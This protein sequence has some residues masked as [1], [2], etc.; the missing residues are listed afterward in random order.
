[1][2][3]P[4]CQNSKCRKRVKEV[5]RTFFS[6][7]CFRKSDAARSWKRLRPLSDKSLLRLKLGNK[8]YTG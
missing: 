1:M 2:K 4:K 6:R 5:M 3:L 7:D 8:L